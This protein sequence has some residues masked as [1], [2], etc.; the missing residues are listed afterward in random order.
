MYRKST[1]WLII[2]I[3]IP[4]QMAMHCGYR[5]HLQTPSCG[6]E[7]RFVAFKLLVQ[8][9]TW[10]WFLT[11]CFLAGKITLQK[12]IEGNRSMYECVVF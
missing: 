8:I 5:L 12:P 6:I 11:E 4:I 9:Y 3:I 10:T 2:I 7:V 1:L